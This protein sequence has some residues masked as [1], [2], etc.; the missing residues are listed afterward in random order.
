MDI[1]ESKPLVGGRGGDDEEQ[2]TKPSSSWLSTIKGQGMIFLV[3]AVVVAFFVTGGFSSGSGRFPS[4]TPAEIPPGIPPPPPVVTEPTERAVMYRP[5]CL[6]HGGKHIQSARILQ[7]SMGTPSQQWSHIPCYSQTVESLKWAGN[8]DTN[9]RLNGYGAPDAI[10]QI[11][12]TGIAHPTRPPILGFGA[13][14]TEAAALNYQTL[15]DRGKETFMELVYGKS[16]LGYALGRVHINSCDFSIKSYSFDDHDGD[17][18]LKHFDTNVTHDV[19]TGMV[20]MMLRAWSTFNTD[21]QGPSA[22]GVDGHFKIYA[23]PWSPPA[24]M[25]L[26]NWR[27]A[28]DAEHAINMTGS[29]EPTCFRE[30]V[31]PSSRYAKAW[32]LYFSKFITACTY[33]TIPK[34]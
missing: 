34:E 17:F 33:R 23:S 12:L 9:L 11:N 32:A 18:R 13:A 4:S 22:D 19:E 8:K 27:D 28:P 6:T 1:D 29:A 10:L 30:G 2:R 20:E 5:F 25:K 16:G 14:F 24:W 26:P 21:W 3:G 7:T 15:S 31:G